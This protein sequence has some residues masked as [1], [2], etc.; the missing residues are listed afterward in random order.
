MYGPFRRGHE[1]FSIIVIKK[2][3]RNGTEN[4]IDIVTLGEIFIT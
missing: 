3:Y 4:V 1:K 2:K